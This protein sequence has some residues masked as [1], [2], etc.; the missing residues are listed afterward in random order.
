MKILSFTTLKNEADIIESFV[1]YNMNIFDKMIIS[2]NLSTDGTFEILK[3]LEKEGCNIEVLIDESKT[4]DEQTAKNKL[5]T[6]TKK[7]YKPDIIIPL[8]AD[9]F[10]TTDEGCNPRIILERDIKMD[11]LFLIRMVNYVVTKEDD[12][13]KNETVLFIPDRIKHIRIESTDK[14]RHYKCIIPK[15]IFNNN[16][17]GR[18][19][20]LGAHNYTNDDGT[21]PKTKTID[22]VYIAH[23]PIRSINRYIYKSIHHSIN[24]L[25]YYS[26]DSG[27]GYHLFYIF[28]KLLE[29]G[30]IPKND[31]YY[32]SKYYDEINNPDR[33]KMIKGI[34][35]CN[36]NTSFCKNLNIKYTTETDDKMII[37]NTLAAS[38]NVIDNMRNDVEKLN[39]EI[40]EK[41]NEIEKLNDEK[42]AYINNYNSVINSKW[43][44]LRKILLFWKK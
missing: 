33:Q 26:S 30:T 24:N 44:K 40:I 1:R 22:S 36:L 21:R 8:D 27:I 16:I 41:N 11:Y 35:K 39:A 7:K 43:W 25:R 14:K 42:N 3:K 12:T 37:K 19:L 4:F 29:Y 34:R 28:D 23:Y 17:K 9:E 10:I 31:F 18:N 6:Y 32:F 2:D 5:L 13:H 20:D 15:K 38:K